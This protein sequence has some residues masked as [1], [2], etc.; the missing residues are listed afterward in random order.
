MPRIASALTVLL[1][2]VT[3]IGFNIA[4]YPVVWEMAAPEGFSQ[5]QQLGQSTAAPQSAVAASSSAIPNL[6]LALKSANALGRE[7]PEEPAADLPPSR[8]SAETT[9]WPSAP[10][11]PVAVGLPAM[12]ESFSPGS[13]EQARLGGQDCW[14]GPGADDQPATRDAGRASVP[15]RPLVAVAPVPPGV[16]PGARPRLESGDGPAAVACAYGSRL[17]VR[18]LPP[19]DQVWNLPKANDQPPRSDDAILIYPAAGMR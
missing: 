10:Q 4:R 7:T 15:E 14:L 8:T 17:T 5:A 19:P 6:T 13:N 16:D 18:R 2:L 11:S 1:T 12:D 9:Y 3:C